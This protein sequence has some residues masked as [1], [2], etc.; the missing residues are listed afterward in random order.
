MRGSGDAA[1]TQAMCCVIWPSSLRLQPLNIAPWC[2]GGFYLLFFSLRRA[3][4]DIS[5]HLSLPV[6]IM[7]AW[8]CRLNAWIVLLTRVNFPAN[9]DSA[10]SRIAGVCIWSE[11]VLFYFSLLLKNGSFKALRFPIINRLIAAIVPSFSFCVA[12]LYLQPGLQ[13]EEVVKRA[14]MYMRKHRYNRDPCSKRPFVSSSTL[15]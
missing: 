7:Q 9:C 6:V 5:A 11:F 1:G 15:R 14:R 8:D 4:I 13:L 3:Y 12:A 10:F 2:H